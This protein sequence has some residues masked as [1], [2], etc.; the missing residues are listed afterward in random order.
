MLTLPGF[1]TDRGMS[2]Q[3]FNGLIVAKTF[4]FACQT[5][6]CRS[7][8]APG[9][10]VRIRNKIHAYPF[11]IV[12]ISLIS[13]DGVRSLNPYIRIVRFRWGENASSEVPLC[14]CTYL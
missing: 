6:G 7:S 10:F 2:W 5:D 13:W 3:V 14:F 9:I 1:R 8:F 11:H 12:S 4:C